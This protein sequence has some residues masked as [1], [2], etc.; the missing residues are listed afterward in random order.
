MLR[1]VKLF[2]IKVILLIVI[3]F[4]VLFTG[5]VVF[6]EDYIPP[7]AYALK[8][9]VKTEIERT[10]PELPEYNYVMGL[11][12]QESCISLKHSKCLNSHSKLSTKREL[13]IGLGQITKAFNADGS[14]R[15]DKLAEMK[16]ANK[17]ALKEADW[18]TIESRPDLQ[19]RIVM[20]MLRDDYRRLPSNLTAENKLAFIDSSYN[21]G[22]TGL[23]K[24]RRAC[25]LSSKCDPKVWF[26]NVENYCMKS[27]K[28]IYGQRSACDIN[29]DHVKQ[30]MTVRMPKY[31][32]HKFIVKG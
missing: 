19:I 18:S 7:Q 11:F 6:A 24:D 27:K 8:V 31:I 23:G 13:G 30:V 32:R 26:G 10:L 12:E 4:W 21:G 14:I 3:G 2:L 15:F 22:F 20:L 28:K 16:A 5:T 29:R 9:P 25:G 1:E 17:E